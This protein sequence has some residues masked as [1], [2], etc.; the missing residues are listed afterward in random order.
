MLSGTENILYVDA[1]S[2]PQPLATMQP[3][4]APNGESDNPNTFDAG[5]A[6]VTLYRITRAVLM[7]HLCVPTE[8]VLMVYGFEM[9]YIGAGEK[10]HENAHYTLTLNDP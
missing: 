10:R 4:K 1:V 2:V 3:A 9:R 8:M 7:C 5:S 6:T